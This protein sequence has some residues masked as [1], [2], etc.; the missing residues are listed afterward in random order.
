MRATEKGILEFVGE[1]DRSCLFRI[2]TQLTLILQ[3]QVT[4]DRHPCSTAFLHLPRALSAAKAA[5]NSNRCRAHWCD[6]RRLRAR[7]RG[8]A[9][10]RLK[11]SSRACNDKRALT[12]PSQAPSRFHA[13]YPGL[14]EASQSYEVGAPVV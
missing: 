12:A 9:A 6:R 7:A 10:L 11:P 5:Q 4:A 13:G 1:P 8:G 2:P 3:L 14:L